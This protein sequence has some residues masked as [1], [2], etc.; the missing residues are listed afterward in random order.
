MNRALLDHYDL[1]G[2]F[3]LLITKNDLL[4]LYFITLPADVFEQ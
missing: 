3:C 1:A 2:L 4:S